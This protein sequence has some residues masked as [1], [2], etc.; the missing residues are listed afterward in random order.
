[1]CGPSL[2]MGTISSLPGAGVGSAEGHMMG[3]VTG[4]VFGVFN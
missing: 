3:G 2:T 4:E 1:M